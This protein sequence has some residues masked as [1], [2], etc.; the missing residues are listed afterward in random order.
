M[1]L[2]A[3]LVFGAGVGRPAAS[4]GAPVIDADCPA[5]F[6]KNQYKFAC[7]FSFLGER[8]IRVTVM[9]T[10]RCTHATV[11]PKSTGGSRQSAGRGRRREGCRGL[12]GPLIRRSE[13]RGNQR[14]T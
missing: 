4:D 12:G 14:L 8:C 13:R 10:N 7:D 1:T 3:R 11:F 9:V 2:S 6:V 5:Q